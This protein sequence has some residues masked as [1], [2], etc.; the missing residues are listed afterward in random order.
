MNKVHESFVASRNVSKNQRNIHWP[1]LNRSGMT[2]H[3]NHSELNLKTEH[4]YYSIG[5][6][7]SVP[8]SFSVRTR[9]G[10]PNVA[11][12]NFLL[13]GYCTDKNNTDNVKEYVY[14]VLLSKFDLIIQCKEKDNEVFHTL[15]NASYVSKDL[16]YMMY[17]RKLD[18]QSLDGMN[19]CDIHFTMWTY[20]NS[21]IG[22]IDMANTNEINALIDVGEANPL[23]VTT[24]GSIYVQDDDCQLMEFSSDFLE[25]KNIFFDF[26]SDCVYIMQDYCRPFSSIYDSLYGGIMT[27]YNDGRVQL[28]AED[29]KK[30][31]GEVIGVI[32][33]LI[34]DCHRVAYQKICKGTENQ[35]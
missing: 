19:L 8:N 28:H 35:V 31:E 30:I 9:L 34:L 15:I 33:D 18:M 20:I 29:T 17:P 22:T 2:F 25:L 12:Y 3:E 5:L 13:Y 26:K 1:Y 24:D 16:Y 4:F 10:S 21:V 14:K 11:M 32:K 23:F 6:P 27:V 7:S